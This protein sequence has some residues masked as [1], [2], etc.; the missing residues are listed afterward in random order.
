MTSSPISEQNIYPRTPIDNV[1]TSRCRM[2][3]YQ[4]A[5]YIEIEKIIGDVTHATEFIVVLINELGREGESGVK[6]IFSV[7]IDRRVDL[8]WCDN[9]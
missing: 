6:V 9:T 4:S 7:E 5:V 1:R 2:C 3:S 8:H